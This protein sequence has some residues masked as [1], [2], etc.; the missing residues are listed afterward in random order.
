MSNTTATPV[1][2]AEWMEERLQLLS[3][4]I[5]N[6]R[7]AH[8]DQDDARRWALALLEELSNIEAVSRRSVHLLTAYALRRR[9]AGAS[10]IAKVSNVTISTAQ[11]RGGSRLAQ[12]VWNEVYPKER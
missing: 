1:E 7:T 10:E 3:K 4:E 8:N 5:Q 2:I 12:E 6:V 11:N 9:L